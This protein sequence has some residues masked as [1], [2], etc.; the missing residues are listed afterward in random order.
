MCCFPDVFWVY[1]LMVDGKCNL[2]KVSY[3]I[4]CFHVTESYSKTL[5]I[6]FPSEVLIP[7][8]KR[9]YTPMFK[10]NRAVL[11]CN[12]AC[13]NFQ[14]SALCDMKMAAPE[15]CRMAGQKVSYRF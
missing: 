13:L 11:F 6:T 14:A 15:S 3:G 1:M 4:L 2:V 8:D 12:R 7:S 5:K 10:L 9:P